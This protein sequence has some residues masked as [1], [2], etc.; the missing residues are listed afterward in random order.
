MYVRAIQSISLVTDTA[1]SKDDGWS[2]LQPNGSLRQEEALSSFVGIISVRCSYEID[3]SFGGDGDRFD[4]SMRGKRLLV[5]KT[6]RAFC[7][8]FSALSDSGVIDGES[9]PDVSPNH[10]LTRSGVCPTML[11]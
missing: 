1:A 6:A 9:S 3:T 7:R 4:V 10:R 2:T 5:F 11:G 8:C